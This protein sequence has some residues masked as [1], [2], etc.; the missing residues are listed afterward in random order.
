[1]SQQKSLSGRRYKSLYLISYRSK[2]L[3][4]DGQMVLKQTILASRSAYFFPKQGGMETKYI[5]TCEALVSSNQGSNF[6]EIISFILAAYFIS[7]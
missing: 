2:F 3:Q 4:L 1:M 5:K 6:D 7:T